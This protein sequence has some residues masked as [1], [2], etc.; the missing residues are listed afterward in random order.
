MDTRPFN[1]RVKSHAK[2]RPSRHGRFDISGYVQGLVKPSRSPQ[3]PAL[4]SRNI[5][6][7]RSAVLEHPAVLMMLI[8]AIK[9]ATPFDFFFA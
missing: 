1:V 9:G 3:T 6:W 5:R 4:P 8:G 7:C 2:R